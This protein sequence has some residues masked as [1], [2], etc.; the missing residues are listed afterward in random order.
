MPPLKSTRPFWTALCVLAGSCGH[1]EPFDQPARVTNGPF[2]AGPDVRLTFNADQNEWPTWTEDGQGILYAFVDPASPTHRCAGLLPVAGGTRLWQLCD[3]RAARHDSANVYTAYALGRGGLLVAEAISGVKNLALPVS[4]LWLADTATPYVRRTLLTLPQAVG[5]TVVN[6]LS[7]IAWTGPTTFIGL[8]QQVNT[9]PHCVTALLP[10][11]GQIA[12]QCNSTDTL[13]AASGGVVVR[14]TILGEQATLDVVGGTLGAI[15]Y[16]LAE[17][18]AS[19]VFTR[20]TDLYIVPAGGGTPLLVPT[21]SASARK[22][23]LGVA[24]KGE[25]CIVARDSIAVEPPRSA[26]FLNGY[27]IPL[28]TMELHQ[29]SLTSGADRILVSNADHIIYATPKVSPVSDAVVVQLGGGWGHVQTFATR[30][31]PV[32]WD[33]DGISALHLYSGFFQ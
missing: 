26:F 32:L 1:T 18:G 5:G 12:T 28:G 19:I 11:S 4:T 17:N 14:G 10:V 22:F 7:D 24:C 6:W 8:G 16:S 15:S 2:S 31:L 3:N 9:E 33:K 29:I 21:A 23:S 13:W 27:T 30:A 25:L 20:G